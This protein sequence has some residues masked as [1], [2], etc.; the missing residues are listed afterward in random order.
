[1]GDVRCHCLL[2]VSSRLPCLRGRYVSDSWPIG[3]VVVH[4]TAVASHLPYDE[5][6]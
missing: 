2:A 6:V 1:M 3:S 5:D 4:L